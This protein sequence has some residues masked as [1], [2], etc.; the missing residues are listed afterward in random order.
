MKTYFKF[1]LFTIFL[2]VLNLR[3]EDIRPLPIGISL[4][5]TNP[6][7]NTLPW[8]KA[9]RFGVFI[10]WT[11]RVNWSQNVICPYEF[12]DVKTK[13]KGSL[14]ESLRDDKKNLTGYKHWEEFNPTKF[15]A[16]E[17]IDL[18]IK[19]GAQFYMLELI[20]DYGWSSFDTPAGTFD[21]A[22][23]DWGKD[24]CEELAKASN[25]RLPVTYHQKQAGGIDFILGGWSSF[26]S[27]WAYDIKR[28]PEFRKM[29]L[30]WLVSHPEKYGKIAALAFAGPYG[31]D[32][33]HPSREGE[34]KDHFNQ[35]NSDYIVNLLK[36]Q[37]WM[38][39]S[40]GFSMKNA[41]GYNPV[42]DMK[43]SS[44]PAY[45]TDLNSQLKMHMFSMESDFFPCWAFG[46]KEN[47]R[48]AREFIKLITMMASRDAN[49]LIRVTPR[50]DGTIEPSHQ[51]VLLTIGKWMKKYGQ[52]IYG[53]RNGPYEP[54]VWGGSVRRGNKIY[55]HI[56]ALSENGKFVFPQLPNG[57]KIKKVSLLNTNTDIPYT[58]TDGIFSVQIDKAITRN[59]NIP[60]RIVEITYENGYNTLNISYNALDNK[61]FKYNESLCCSSV[62]KK[63][64]ITPWHNAYPKYPLIPQTKKVSGKNIKILLRPSLDK[65]GDS[66][67][68]AMR[69]KNSP[70]W[71]PPDWFEF[72]KKSC[73]YS[74]VKVTV[75][76]S[77]PQLVNA[78]SLCEKGER[79][80]NW[81]LRLFN[82]DSKQWQT[83]YKT[84][85]GQMGMFDYYLASP[86]K[87][88][89]FEV[90]VN[91]SEFQQKMKAPL[92]R[93]IRCYNCIYK[94]GQKD[95]SSSSKKNKKKKKDKKKK[96]KKK[97][98]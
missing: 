8:F 50:P 46:Y 7:K 71:S 42:F 6:V 32:G 3:A 96:K 19:A 67:R 60:D 82:E 36:M 52:T 12:E 28:Y 43:G 77:S 68:Y 76:M 16:K 14:Y 40:K 30:Y 85:N 29:S 66:P 38:I 59:I 39:L 47:S 4:D 88:Q 58:N 97:K 75:E 49:F 70:Y 95:D 61:H 10:D 69:L 35:K 62:D 87:T 93:W 37:P 21:F 22:A 51:Q 13:Q 55:L 57:D 44:L 54:G 90:I 84:Q 17:W 33:E 86:V 64:K 18:F 24:L 2:T 27:R 20:D 91:V 48:T 63:V 74:Q 15:N 11:P 23:T 34:Y 98:E 31:G 79:I 45:K 56:T 92:F 81:E 5:Y 53:T 80:K 89:K 83:V 65:K 25:G 41:K 1:F 78:F 9:A 73:E 26:M 94:P 72:P